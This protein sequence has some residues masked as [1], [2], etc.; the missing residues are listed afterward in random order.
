MTIG[1]GLTGLGMLIFAVSV[2]RELLRKRAPA[3]SANVIS[4]AVAAGSLSR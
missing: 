1:N 3:Q 2:G 4:K